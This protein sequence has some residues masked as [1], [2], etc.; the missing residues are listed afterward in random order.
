MYFLV[1]FFRGD[2]LFWLQGRLTN[3]V[4]LNLGY[5][6][7]VGDLPDKVLSGLLDL[8]DIEL[9]NNYF[10]GKVPSLCACTAL[11]SASFGRVH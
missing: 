6:Q 11:S 3:L 7:M 8:Y 10:T 4:Y 9:Q 2:S 5:N 1:G